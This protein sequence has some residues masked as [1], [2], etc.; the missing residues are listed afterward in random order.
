MPKT[1]T[2]LMWMQQLPQQMDFSIVVSHQRDMKWTGSTVV[3]EFTRI[4]WRLAKSFMM[5]HHRGEIAYT[6]QSQQGRHFELNNEINVDR[7]RWLSV[8]FDL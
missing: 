3:D 1:A 5:G 7:R 2:S 6:V 8:K 4:D